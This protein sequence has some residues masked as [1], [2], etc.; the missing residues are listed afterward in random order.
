[1]KFAI[2]ENGVVVNLAVAD[3][4][5]AD[6]WIQSDTAAMGDIYSNG[7]FTTPP[8]PQVP[9]PA[10]VTNAQ[11]RQALIHSGISI[12]S[13]DALI[14]EIA[15]PVERE[16]AFTQW[17]YGNMIRRNAELVVALSDDLGLTAEELDDLFRLAAT[18]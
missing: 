7:E 9:V 18:L 4:A 13:V 17:E 12:A 5:L 8:A 2:I 14:Q 16:I 15:D 3:T 11:A 10:E 1:M 6:N